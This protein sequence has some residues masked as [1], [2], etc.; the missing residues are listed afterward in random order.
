MQQVVHPLR[1]GLWD[2][3]EESCA[4]PNSLANSFGWQSRVTSSTSVDTTSTSRA[5]SLRGTAMAKKDDTKVPKGKGRRGEL[6][7]AMGD[8]SA[9]TVS[10][11]QS[12][13]CDAEHSSLGFLFTDDC[14]PKRQYR[15]RHGTVFRASQIT[16]LSQ[17]AASITF[18]ITLHAIYCCKQ[19]CVKTFDMVTT[20]KSIS[21]AF[22][23]LQIIR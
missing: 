12:S 2:D 3:D 21:Q 1:D 5:K 19:F 7:L 6:R 17:A 16:R 18:N 11:S 22:W 15:N 10:V 9:Y 23:A 14:Q 8:Q 4:S 20:S 13:P